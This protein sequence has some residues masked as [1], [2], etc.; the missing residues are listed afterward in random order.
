MSELL[1]I[2]RNAVLLFSRA[3]S[4]EANKMLPRRHIYRFI[5][6]VKKCSNLEFSHLKG[7]QDW[8]IEDVFLLQVGTY[9]GVLIHRKQKPLTYFVLIVLH[10]SAGGSGTS[11]HC[12]Y[13]CMRVHTHTPWHVHLHHRIIMM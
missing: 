13:L 10:F 8:Q 2:K 1:F 9:W 12:T 4:K 7:R 11:Y 3:L 5:L 6:E